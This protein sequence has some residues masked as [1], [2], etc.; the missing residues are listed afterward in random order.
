[1]Y[2]FYLST[3]LA[4][5]YRCFCVFFFLLFEPLHCESTTYI[6][7]LEF[8]QQMKDG[9]I[10]QRSSGSS[11]SRN[12]EQQR[13]QHNYAYTFITTIANQAHIE[14]KKFEPSTPRQNKYT[15]TRSR[16]YCK[17]FEFWRM[18]RA[19]TRSNNK[20]LSSK[21]ISIWFWMLVFIVCLFVRANKNSLADNLSMD[22]CGCGC[23]WLFYFHKIS[24]SLVHHMR[25]IHECGK[26]GK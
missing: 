12:M 10:V 26:V 8:I 11:H 15:H 19:K 9:R 7:S 4:L 5:C 22:R 25:T 17:W 14:I 2:S 23:C 18:P 13:Q 1:M 24:C 16:F 6:D 3:A 20:I 21:F